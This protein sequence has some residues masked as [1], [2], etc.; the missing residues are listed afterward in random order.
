M[1]GDPNEPGIS[2]KAK[3]YRSDPEF[4]AIVK[5]E[6]AKGYRRRNPVPMQPAMPKEERLRRNNEF[7]KSKLA[8]DVEYKKSRY[9]Y[10]KKYQEIHREKYR[11]LVF[12]HYGLSCKCCGEST[13]KLLTIDHINNDG[14]QH[15]QQIKSGFYKWIVD[16]NYPEGLQTLCMN[17]NWGR[18]KNRGICP[19]KEV[20]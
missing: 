1:L 3:R 19:H 11:Y 17:C 20:V 6:N 10:N 5:L 16:S 13:I 12:S 4:R 9:E 8:V 7:M 2:A 15:R 18:A 14:K